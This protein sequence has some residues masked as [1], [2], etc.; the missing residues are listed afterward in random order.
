MTEKQSEYGAIHGYAR[1]A[2][3]VLGLLWTGLLLLVQRPRTLA[4]RSLWRQRMCL[5]IAAGMGM[6]IDVIGR[7]PTTG[8]LVSN[9]LSYLDAVVLGALLPAVFV[10]KSEVRQWPLVGWLTAGG[11]TIYLKRENVRAAAEVNRLLAA[12]MAENLPTVIFPEGTTTGATDPLPFHPALFEP[13]SRSQAPVWPAALA[14]TIDGSKEGVPEF[15]CYWGEMTFATHLVRLMRQRNLRAVVR[16]AD[17]PVYA[18]KRN[19][20]AA[21]SHEAVSWM[22]QHG[23][24]V[25]L[26]ADARTVETQQATP[27]QAF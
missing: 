22:L 16:I 26:R 25:P 2:H 9:H 11:G 27:A 12:A 17:E 21:R 6:Q 24:E 3:F 4:E 20:V 19:E 14:Y 5:R 10:A 13:A 7:V 8:M 1:L 23:L 18:A 15:V